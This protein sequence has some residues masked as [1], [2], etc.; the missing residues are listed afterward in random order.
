MFKTEEEILKILEEK[1]LNSDPIAKQIHDVITSPMP[2]SGSKA[3]AMIS[4]SSLI[5][6]LL[7]KMGP[8][9]KLQEKIKERNLNSSAINLAVTLEKRE[10]IIEYKCLIADALSQF[11]KDAT[12]IEFVI[13]WYVDCIKNVASLKCLAYENIGLLRSDENCVYYDRKEA[14][15]CFDRLFELGKKDDKVNLEHPDVLFGYANA[16]ADS[17]YLLPAIHIYKKAADKGHTKAKVEFQKLCRKCNLCTNCGGKFQ[18][19]F[20]KKCVSCGSV[21]NY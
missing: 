6:T 14:N 5:P 9:K 10:K 13:T 19:I 20:K 21:K 17:L 7:E 15:I 2:Q 1:D 11:R 3:F 4:I 12:A 8:S 18:G 16:V